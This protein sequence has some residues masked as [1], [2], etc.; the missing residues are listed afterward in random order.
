MIQNAAT[1][2]EAKLQMRALAAAIDSELWKI[3]SFKAYSRNPDGVCRCSRREH[4]RQ[5]ATSPPKAERLKSAIGV[6][7]GSAGV[8][9]SAKQNLD[10]VLPKVYVETAIKIAEDRRSLPRVIS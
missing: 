1:S 7:K 2:T 5:S 6:L 10:A 9:A 8:V 4:L 3:D